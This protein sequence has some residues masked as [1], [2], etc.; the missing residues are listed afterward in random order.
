MLRDYL[1]LMRRRARLLILTV[2][3]TAAGAV[4]YSLLQPPLYAATAQVYVKNQGLVLSQGVLTTA[5]NTL[6]ADRSIQTQAMLARTISI[7]S[8]ALK[9]WK[10]GFTAPVPQGAAIS[11]VSPQEL[12]NHS[13]VT[14]DARSSSGTPSAVS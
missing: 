4:G 12:L 3:L 13:S 11:S 7:A 2:L 5:P 9:P 10:Q 8:Q 1:T 14:P 6:T